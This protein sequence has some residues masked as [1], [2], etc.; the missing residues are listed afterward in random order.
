MKR[1]FLICMAALMSLSMLKAAPAYNRPIEFKQAD[2]TTITVYLRGDERVHW[3][4]SLDGYTLLNQ[5]GQLYYAVLDESG[6]M[7]PSTVKAHAQAD[8][9][10]AEAMFVRKISKGLRYSASQIE[11]RMAKWKAPADA[12]AKTGKKEIL[13]D[14]VVRKIPVILVN[15]QNVKMVTPKESYDSL[16][17]MQGYQ[18]HGCA[19][20]FVDYFLDNSRG[21]FHFQPDVYGPVDLPYTRYYY[22]NNDMYGND[23]NAAQMIEDACRLADSLYDVDFS[24]Y[25]ADGDGAVDGMHIIYAGQ[26]EE[27]TLQGEAVWAHQGFL[28]R[29]LTLDGVDMW[30]YAC[31]GELS[32]ENDFAYIGA[33]VHEMSH[34]LR[35]PDLYDCDY[36][37]SGGVSVDPGE[38]DIMAYGTYNNGGKTPPLHNAWCRS[39]LGWLERQSLEDSCVIEMKNVEE[40]TKAFVIESPTEGEYFVLDYRGGESRW[41]TAIPGYGL[42]IYA[43]NENV[44]GFGYDLNQTNNNPARRGFYIKQ[45]DGGNNSGAEM[46]P[47]TPYPTADNTEFTDQSSPNSRTTTGAWTQKPVTEISWMDSSAGITFL[48]MGGGDS[49]YD[50]LGHVRAVPGDTTGG[51]DDTTSVARLEAMESVKVWPNPVSSSFTVSAQEALSYVALYNLQGQMCLRREAHGAESLEVSVSA[52]PDGFYVVEVVSL[53]G[54]RSFRGKLLKQL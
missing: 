27:T 16:I 5:D 8:R 24:Q 15:F 9:T 18:A 52:L 35:L 51:G 20:S 25:D 38:F 12:A 54:R 44:P 30:M 37:G 33:L 7:V 42:L 11:S 13:T 50:N 48:F 40:A 3:V 6:N 14:T 39:E 2:G 26:G 21:L 45:A 29:S 53:D 23:Q 43:I 10:E 46:G 41:D 34:V 47:E 32:H 22:G 28:D 1:V 36:D 31:S 49:I 4:E 19:G 17:T